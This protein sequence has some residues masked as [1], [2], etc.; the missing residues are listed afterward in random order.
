MASVRVS[1]LLTV[2]SVIVPHLGKS[3]IWDHTV[4]V[5]HTT[6]NDTE[7]LPP[8]S[9]SPCKTLGRALGYRNDSTLY[10]LMSGSYVLESYVDPFTNLSDISIIGN[11][12][13][14]VK[15]VCNKGAGLAFVNVSRVSVANAIFIGCGAVRNSTSSILTSNWAASREVYNLRQFQVGLYFYLCT[16]LNVTHVTISNSN[17]TGLVI[18]DTDGYVS[19]VD[20]V[21]QNNSVHVNTPFSEAGG[22][23]VYVEFS[24]C[25]P[26][27]TCGGNDSL[28][29]THNSNSIYFFERCTF[30]GNKASNIMANSSSTFIFL[31]KTNH[32]AFGRGGGLS[33]FFN[34]NAT[35]N[36]MI[37][38]N[39]SFNDNVAV[40]GGGLFVEF[41]D[42]ATGNTV[43]TSYC[44]FVSNYLRN[45]STGGGAIRIGYY[46]FQS[47]N[48]SNRINISN[49]NFTYNEASYGGGI[50]ISP[51]L[52]Q[53]DKSIVMIWISECA[54]FSNYAKIGSAIHI[55]LFS[56]IPQGSLPHIIV[57]N[58]TFKYNFLVGLL[59]AKNPLELGVGSVYVNEVPVQF[60]D[61]VDFEYNTGTALAVVGTHI[62]FTSCKAWFKGNHGVRG[63][64]IALLGAAWMLINENTTMIFDENHASVE[65]G[66]IYNVY[67]EKGSAETSTNCFLKYNDPSIPADF[68]TAHF[69]F[70]N[71]TASSGNN[72]IYSS[73]ILPCALLTLSPPSKIF[74][75]NETYWNF[76]GQ[77][78]TDQITTDI[79]NMAILGPSK[80]YPGYPFNLN[81]TI[82]DDLEH[83]ILSQSVFTG[84]IISSNSNSSLSVDANIS[85]PYITGGVVSVYGKEGINY[86]LVMDSATTRSWHVNV[87]I[88]MMACPPGLTL[89]Q[90]TCTCH[91][92]NPYGLYDSSVVLCLGPVKCMS[93]DV[94]NGAFLKQGYWMGHLDN[95][96]ELY[97]TLCPPGYCNPNMSGNQSLTGYVKLPTSASELEAAI[98]SNNRKGVACRECKEGYSPAINSY[99]YEC[100]MCNNSETLKNSLKYIGTVYIP[101]VL[102]FLT[103]I[104]FNIHLTTGPANAFI[105]YSQ[106]ISSTFDLT[107]GGQISYPLVDK[108]AMVYRTIYGILNL[109]FFLNLLY[110]FC[111]SASLETFGCHLA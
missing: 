39:C 43:Q 12:S 65:G 71:N 32:E 66:A 87:S 75:W 33:I 51:A 63:G 85:T 6:G 14:E 106:I 27:I 98:C 1:L 9:R 84:V 101:L 42:S 105:L 24:Y 95:S 76:S 48:V 89:F 36:Q 74:C 72:S 28:V 108:V 58:C 91:I 100:I 18:Y 102:L 86:L 64:A 38:L 53:S 5:D 80:S 23:G 45:E 78:C 50:S 21:F 52:Q 54:F 47:V 37:V 7:C 111:L 81:L 83:N 44:T 69:I 90:D 99:T 8:E 16:S 41:H 57:R 93:T 82:T 55:S 60:E 61:S 77:L 40:W 56:L 30:S 19:I 15:V 34:H 67:I 22:G 94:D 59:A 109:D 107:A 96:S 31:D 20:S 92:A 70:I 68:W 35:N 79:G 46:V 2:V 62:N 11:A 3:Q 10:F 4:A 103:I 13:G 26:G 17:A 29:S 97:V 49:C 73:T 25:T 88:E 104:I 110:P